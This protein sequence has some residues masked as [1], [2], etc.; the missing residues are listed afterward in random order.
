[1]PYAILGYN[2]SLH[3]TT[4]QRPIVIIN[5][6]LDFNNFF[7]IDINKQLFTN[8]IDNHKKSTLEIYK[9]LNLQ[10]TKQKETIIENQNKNR[11]DPLEYQP[12]TLAYHQTNARDKAK[13]RFKS[14][15]ITTNNDITVQTPANTYHKSNIRRPLINQQHFPPQNTNDRPDHHDQISGNENDKP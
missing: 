3:S 8:Y 15:I 10:L 13:P 5:G 1:M 9:N 12:G 11:Q 6:H 2:H 14:H 7:D 4:K